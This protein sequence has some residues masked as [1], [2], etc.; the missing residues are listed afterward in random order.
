MTASGRSL[1]QLTHDFKHS[2]EAH[3]YLGESCQRHFLSRNKGF[4]PMSTHGLTTHTE[5]FQIGEPFVEFSYNFG[6]VQVGR[7]FAGHNHH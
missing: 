2:R 1:G 6:S 3:Q 5:N 7:C 4:E